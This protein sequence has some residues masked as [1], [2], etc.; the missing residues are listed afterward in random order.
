[1]NF[2]GF[3]EDDSFVD[4]EDA[5]FAYGGRMCPAD[6]EGHVLIESECRRRLTLTPGTT[7]TTSYNGASWTLWAPRGYT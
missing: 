3:E 2:T 5:C 1:M 7:A 4:Y 6:M